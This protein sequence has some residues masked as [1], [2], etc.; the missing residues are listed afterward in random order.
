MADTKH[1]PGPWNVTGVMVDGE[2][3]PEICIGVHTPHGPLTVAVA[4]GGL[5]GQ[6]AN[7]LVL[8]AAPE[9][10][11]ALQAVLPWA[12]ELINDNHPAMKAAKAAIAKATGEQP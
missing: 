5:E 1:T 6:E 10:L 3:H 11:A 8:A 2:P 7:A 9:L 12:A 4:L